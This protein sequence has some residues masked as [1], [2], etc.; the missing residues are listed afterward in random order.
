MDAPTEPTTL[1]AAEA[2]AV[3]AGPLL[4]YLEG[5]TRDHDL[6]E[7]LV[8]ECFLRLAREEAAGRTPAHTRGWLHRVALNLLMSHGRHA[9]VAQRELARLAPEELRHPSPESEAAARE[10]LAEAVGAAARL[11][12]S[13]RQALALAAAGCTNREMAA[14]LDVSAEAAR[15]RLCRARAHLVAAMAA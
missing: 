3:H 15:A 4:H 11:S 10:T 5:R 7:D 14:A 12:A 1:S 13:E 6:A 2:Y 8:G 9:Q